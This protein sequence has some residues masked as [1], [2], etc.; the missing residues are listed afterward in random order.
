MFRPKG[1]D[2]PGIFAACNRWHGEEK[3]GAFMDYLKCT[4]L[5]KNAT[6]AGNCIGCG[7]CEQ[8]CPQGIAIREELR[9]AKK[10]L[11]PPFIPV[12][13]KAIRLFTKF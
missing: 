5:R 6:T 7:K 13:K 2:I 3:F 11:E 10:A 8:H 9:Q 1:V 12:I 4:V